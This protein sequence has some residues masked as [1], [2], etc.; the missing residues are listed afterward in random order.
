MWE[1]F[2][3]CIAHLL[4]K[5]IQVTQWHKSE[6]LQGVHLYLSFIMA[7]DYLEENINTIG[8][9][10][11]K[12]KKLTWLRNFHMSIYCSWIWLLSMVGNNG[13]VG[14]SCCS[15]HCLYPQYSVLFI[16]TGKSHSVP[17]FHCIKKPP[18]T[19]ET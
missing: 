14:L 2:W 1:T 7:H 19:L 15:V 12:K 10:L 17:F 6:G 13:F 11:K 8:S 5:L 3:Q 4:L 16:I 9:T 18:T